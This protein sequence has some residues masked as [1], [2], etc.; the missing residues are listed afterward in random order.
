M[1]D[2]RVLPHA[3]PRARPASRIGRCFVAAVLALAAAAMALPAAAQTYPTRP[4]RLVVPFP[5][6]RS[7]DI[8]GRLLAQRLSETSGQAVIV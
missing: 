2:G 4:V 5:P 1:P 8:T 3:L 7:L 6:G